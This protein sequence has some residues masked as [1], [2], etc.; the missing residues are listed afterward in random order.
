MVERGGRKPKSQYRDHKAGVSQEKTHLYI[1]TEH[2]TSLSRSFRPRNMRENCAA[3]PRCTSGTCPSSRARS[4]CTSCSPC[5]ERWSGSSW[6]WIES[7]RRRVDSV[8]SSIQQN[9]LVLALLLRAC[10]CPL[11]RLSYAR[12]LHRIIALYYQLSKRFM[13]KNLTPWY[14]A[15]SYC[16]SFFWPWRS[17]RYYSHDSAAKGI[18]YISGT[19]LDNR[20]IRADWD[21]GFIEGRQYGRGR[22]GGQVRDDYR[23]GCI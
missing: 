3:A 18:A 6:V 8:L 1:C 13:H 7:R 2:R 12:K 21:M 23:Q 19:K 14:T 15:F 20:I 22:S 11:L 5:A 4:R 9:S 16:V 10:T 17:N